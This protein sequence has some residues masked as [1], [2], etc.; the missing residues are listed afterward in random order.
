MAG[1][2]NYILIVDVGVIILLRSNRDAIL[3]N[4]FVKEVP[5]GSL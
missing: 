3:A 2:N 1:M 5:Y 4:L